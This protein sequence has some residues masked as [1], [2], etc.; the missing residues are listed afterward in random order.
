MEVVEEHPVQL[1]CFIKLRLSRVLLSSIKAFLANMLK[2][3][4]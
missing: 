1:A 3:V 4:C 2:L